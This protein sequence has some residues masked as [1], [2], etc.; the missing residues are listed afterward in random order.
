[1]GYDEYSQAWIEYLSLYLQLDYQFVRYVISEARI[2]GILSSVT[3]TAE[4]LA[5]IMSVY[6]RWSQSI[7]Q[8]KAY[9]SGIEDSDSKGLIEGLREARMVRGSVDMKRLGFE[10]HYVDVSQI[11]TPIA[12]VAE[13]KFVKARGLLDTDEDLWGLLA[14][15]MI[16]MVRNKEPDYERL[17][18]AGIDMLWVSRMYGEQ[19]TDQFSGPVRQI[20]SVLIDTPDNYYITV[21]STKVVW[22]FYKSD[23]VSEMCRSATYQRITYVCTLEYKHYL[24]E[25][26]AVVRPSHEVGKVSIS[27]YVRKENREAARY[28]LIYNFGRIKEKVRQAVSRERALWKPGVK[29]ERL[30]E[31]IENLN[32]TD[33][34]GNGWIKREMVSIWSDLGLVKVF[35][36]DSDKY[37]CA[38]L[39]SVCDTSEGW[40]ECDVAMPAAGVIVH[41]LRNKAGKQYVAIRNRTNERHKF[42]ELS[43]YRV[44]NTDPLDLRCSSNAF[45]ECVGQR[46]VI[47]TRSKRLGS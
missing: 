29:L 38:W 40:I 14:E 39:K 10:D 45:W 21:P 17:D 20:K 3:K 26:A 34:K 35:G 16:G 12:G 19:E 18:D 36:G 28:G 24:V 33:D 43:A 5:S 31:A 47:T 9:L 13:L 4:S 42:Y 30:L 8:C 22:V 25:L 32:L 2:S 27:D 6:E 23:A 15:C 44:V 41:G 7:S 11:A 37:N 1:M 46:G